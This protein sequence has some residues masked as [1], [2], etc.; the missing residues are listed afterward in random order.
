M[1]GIAGLTVQRDAG[2]KVFPNDRGNLFIHLQQRQLCNKLH[3]P[4]PLRR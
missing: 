1:K 2:L 4:K 3:R